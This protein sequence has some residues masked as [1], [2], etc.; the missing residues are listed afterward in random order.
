VLITSVRHEDAIVGGRFDTWHFRE[1]FESLHEEAVATNNELYLALQEDVE[2]LPHAV[3]RYAAYMYKRLQSEGLPTAPGPSLPRPHASKRRVA[4]NFPAETFMAEDVCPE[5]LA[6]TAGDPAGLACW[7]TACARTM[8]GKPWR[9]KL[10]E[11]LKKFNLS[12]TRE[13]RESYFTGVGGRTTSVWAYKFPSALAGHCGEIE[14]AE[15][16]QDIPLLLSR[17]LQKFLKV[18]IDMGNGT[19]DIGSLGV[20]DK[21]LQYTA[22]GHPGISI[23]DFDPKQPHP[24]SLGIDS[25]AFHVVHGT[26][27]GD[28][29]AEDFEIGPSGVLWRSDANAAAEGA[30]LDNKDGYQVFIAETDS[31]SVKSMSGKKSKK[32]RKLEQ[33]ADEEDYRQQSTLTRVRPQ[34]RVPVGAGCLL[35]QLFCGQLGLT[36]LAMMCYGYQ[37]GEPLDINLGWNATTR[38]GRTYMDYQFQSEDPY[39]VVISGPCGPWGEWSRCNLKKGGAARDTVMEARAL[40]RPVLNS[41]CRAVLHRLARCRHVFLEAFRQ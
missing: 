34:H 5:V 3:L 35:K 40:G 39:C 26:A 13:A 41:I 6:S 11:A 17:Q 12:P 2:T 14:S 38:A 20:V 30:H 37:C 9:L 24:W 31:K 27:C 10:E 29:I 4:H 16:E 7:D 25:E 18:K 22:G 32:M 21:K 8:H 33:Q 28:Q 19:C 36:W 23:V 1:L 15:V